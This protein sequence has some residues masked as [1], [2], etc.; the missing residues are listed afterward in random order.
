M[1]KNEKEVEKVIDISAERCLVISVR[2]ARIESPLF[3][4]RHRRKWASTGPQK[5]SDVTGC[6]EAGACCS[7]P[8]N[9]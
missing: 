9:Y 2:K 5:D 3:R 8:S 6:R 7:R 4:S 1:E